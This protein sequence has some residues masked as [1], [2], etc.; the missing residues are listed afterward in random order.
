MYRGK[1]WK[2]IMLASLVGPERQMNGQDICID[3]I[4]NV[5]SGQKS[6]IS[7]WVTGR[8]GCVCQ[9]QHVIC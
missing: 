3:Q 7:W 8:E 1:M 9:L 5:G 4:S 6:D 2:G